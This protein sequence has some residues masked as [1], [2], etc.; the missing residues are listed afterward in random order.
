MITENNLTRRVSQR[1]LL[2]VLGVIMITVVGLAVT[3]VRALTPITGSYTATDKLAVGALVSLRKDTPDEIAAASI[4]NV[5]GLLGVVINAESSLITLTSGAS[6]QV[7]VATT[8]TVPVLVSNYNGEIARG[9]HITTSPISGVGMKATN[10]A[11]VVGIAQGSLNVNNGKTATVKDSSGKEQSIL[12]GEVPVLVNVS[13]YFKE[14]DKTLIPS[15][16]QNLA[17]AIAG[18][19]VNTLPI[20]ISAAIFF[21]MLIVVASI[22]YSMV[23]SSIISVG[24]NPMSQSAIYRDMVQLSALVLAI[25]AVGV[26]AIY[27]VLTRL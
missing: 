8:G 14:P 3:S 9:D 11:R 20:L 2:V 6:N 5:D 12:L 23:K 18:K 27:L 25:L 4:N 22:V 24:R 10:N 1:V 21:V 19:S 26:I 15:A 13:Y 7:A 16:F 17:N